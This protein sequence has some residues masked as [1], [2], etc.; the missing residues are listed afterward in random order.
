MVVF[1]KGSLG[2]FPKLAPSETLTSRDRIRLQHTGRKLTLKW[3]KGKWLKP[4]IVAI[5]VCFVENH[6]EIHHRWARF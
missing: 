2:A 1:F 6:E 3:P 4:P 5:W